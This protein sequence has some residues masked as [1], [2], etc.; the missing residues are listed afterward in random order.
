MCAG[1]AEYVVFW[2]IPFAT[3]IALGLFRL[4]ALLVARSM[5][6]EG[7]A[8]KDVAHILKASSDRPMLPWLR[9]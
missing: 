6:R 9:R 3:V 1:D 4:A 2:L 7:F 8:A 5:L